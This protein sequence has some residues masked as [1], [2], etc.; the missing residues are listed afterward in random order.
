MGEEL[1]IGGI[2][3]PSLMVWA[4]VAVLLSL[5]LTWLLS[6]AGFYRFVWHR[7]LFDICL[8]VILWGELAALA[9]GI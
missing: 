8:V 2:L 5:P 7:G 1:A 9:A 3:L 4:V 6:I